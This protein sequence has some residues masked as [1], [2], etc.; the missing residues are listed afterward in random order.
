MQ[1]LKGEIRCLPAFVL[2]L[3]SYG[4][5]AHRS[6]RPLRTERPRHGSEPISRVIGGW[7][8]GQSVGSNGPRESIRCRDE[9]AEAKDGAALNQAIVC[10]RPAMG[11]NRPA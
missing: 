2:F 11:K 6:S 1:P 5:G 4:I 3:T 8:G 9:Y 10:D 7:G